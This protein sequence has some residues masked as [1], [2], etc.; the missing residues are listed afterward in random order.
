MDATKI[1]EFINKFDELY[2][3]DRAFIF[4]SFEADGFTLD[5]KKQYL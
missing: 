1:D 4:E 5:E 3:D 2:R